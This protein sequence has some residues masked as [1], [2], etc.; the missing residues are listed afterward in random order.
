LVFSSIA[1]L[2]F[3]LPICIGVYR[4]VPLKLRNL[5][6]LVFSLFFYGWGEP[7]Y[8]IIM[9]VSIG[10]DYTHG[11]LVEKFRSE[12][13]KAKAV[14]ASSVFFNL[15]LLFFFKYFDFFAVNLSRIPGISIAPLGLELPIGISFYTFQ[16][17]SYTID[18]YRQ[19]AR[20]PKNIITFGTYVTMFPQLIA[21]PI[22][23]YKSV[24][25][26]LEYRDQ[27]VEKFSSGVEIFVIGLCKKVLLANSI[28]KLWDTV[29][30]TEPAML[31]AT[32]AWLGLLAFGLQ[33]YFDFS[34]YSDMAIGLGRMFGFE[35]MKNF[36]HPYESRSISEFWRRWHISLTNWFREY[37]YIPLGGE[38]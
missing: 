7:V 1:F 18:V 32:S 6:L 20:A 4:L 28:G 27:G 35:L 8:I 31:S 12:P 3:Y 9:F 17:M 25:E 26:Q 37:V 22:I 15:A 21:G 16:T 13:K 11:M 14:V 5:V 36:D 38:P 34:G 23:N 2:F 10:I 29:A 24:A 19:D 30:A 33:I